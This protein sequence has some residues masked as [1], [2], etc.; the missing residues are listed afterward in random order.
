MFYAIWICQQKYCRETPQLRIKTY[1]CKAPSSHK[2]ENNNGDLKD[3]SCQVQSNLSNVCYKIAPYH[4]IIIVCL[5]NQQKVL[6]R[7]S[8]LLKSTSRKQN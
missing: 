1:C 2:K 8:E 6:E 3:D 4:I 7:V 5:Q